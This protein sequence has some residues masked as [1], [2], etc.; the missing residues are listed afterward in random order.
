MSKLV[1]F[2]VEK[3]GGLIKSEKQAQFFLLVLVVVSLVI[4]ISLILG[5]A[6]KKELKGT[7]YNPNA[8]YGGRELPDNY[9]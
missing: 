7:E 8:G 6:G 4:S 2:V 3:S 9:R 1:K 5:S